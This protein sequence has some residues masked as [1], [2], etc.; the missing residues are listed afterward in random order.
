MSMIPKSGH[1]FSDKI[2]LK[3]KGAE[4]TRSRVKLKSMIA[5][6]GHRFSDKIMIKEKVM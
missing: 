5:K 4:K 1:R 3:Q 6:S 2:I